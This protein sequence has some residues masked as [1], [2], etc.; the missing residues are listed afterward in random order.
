M[1]LICY[2]P[3]TYQPSRE[4]QSQSNHGKTELGQLDEA[5]HRPFFA[6]FPFCDSII[7]SLFKILEVSFLKMLMEMFLLLE[8]IPTLRKDV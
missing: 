1:N 8:L 2:Q 5:S 3:A 6:K 7:P 4:R